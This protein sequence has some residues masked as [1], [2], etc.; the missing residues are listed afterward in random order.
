[1]SSVQKLKQIAVPTSGLVIGNADGRGEA[2]AAG[3]DGQVLRIIGGV[4]TWGPAVDA[5]TYERRYFTEAG[6]STPNTTTHTL[7]TTLPAE[8]Q[9]GSKDS[10]VVTINGMGVSPTDF[11]LGGTGPYTLTLNMTAIGYSLDSTDTVFVS[12]QQSV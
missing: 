3:T 5:V 7:N 11:S 10:M 9:G 12:Y 8:L 6:P 4:P 1:M 2:L